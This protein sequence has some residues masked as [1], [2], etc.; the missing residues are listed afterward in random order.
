LNNTDG[1]VNNVFLNKNNGA[2]LY[3]NKNFAFF[4][5]TNWEKK[6]IQQSKV[7]FS[8]LSVLHNFRLKNKIK[9]TIYQRHLLDPENFNRYNDGVIQASFLRACNKKELN[10]EVDKNSSSKMATI[11]ISS[12]EDN[13]NQDSAPYEFLMAICIGKLSLL[14]KD[15]SHIIEKHEENSDNI[16]KVL[17]RVIKSKFIDV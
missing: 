1:L 13:A 2:R 9:Q 4:N 8:I 3:L 15:L 17:I 16:I 5:F 10:F 12:I 6:D 7:Y 14:K 11:I